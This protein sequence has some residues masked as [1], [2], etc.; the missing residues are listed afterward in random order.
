MEL[1]DKGN[2]MVFTVDWRIIIFSIVLG[3]IVLAI[4]IA[5]LEA[6]SFDWLLN[7]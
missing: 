1:K 4:G 2:K 5:L 7:S 6:G 3:A